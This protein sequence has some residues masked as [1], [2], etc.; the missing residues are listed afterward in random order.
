LRSLRLAL[1]HWDA[2]SLEYWVETDGTVATR[3]NFDAKISNHD[4]QS[5]YWPAFRRT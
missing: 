2:Y 5:T 3:H 4:L 1:Q